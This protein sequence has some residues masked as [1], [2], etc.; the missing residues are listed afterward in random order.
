VDKKDVTDA[1][2]T[3]LAVGAMILQ[4]LV[5]ALAL[6]ALV[7]LVWRPARRVLVEA[8]E[9]L[10]GGELWIAWAIAL[11][12]TLGSLFFSEYSDFVPCRLCWFQRIA[13]YP[14]AIVLLVGALRRDV[15][16][17]VQYALVFPVAG[18]LVSIYHIYIENNPGAESASCKMGVPCSVKWIDE[19]GYI[20]MPTLALT[21]F[22]SILALLLL[23]WSRRSPRGGVA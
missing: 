16:A 13:M 21:A 1:V 4:V 17:A 14:L 7:A 5:V 3:T 2:A 11:I 22:L 23:A 10:F 8:R 20:T 12:A 19:F 15:R 9:S 6:V 18:A